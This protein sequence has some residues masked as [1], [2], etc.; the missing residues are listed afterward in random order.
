M[1]LPIQST[2]E[3]VRQCNPALVQGVGMLNSTLIY[4]PSQSSLRNASYQQQC[5]VCD[6]PGH[7]A[8]QYP[9][10]GNQEQQPQQYS[11]QSYSQQQYDT[12]YYPLVQ[13]H[14]PPASN[15]SRPVQEDR[16]MMA[17]TRVEE[18]EESCEKTQSRLLIVHK[19]DQGNEQL[20]R[21]P[22]I[23]TEVLTSSIPLL[24]QRPRVHFAKRAIP[25]AC[26]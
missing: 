24:R 22:P 4:G 9:W 10:K 7:Y 25:S 5:Y 21:P 8:Q 11:G 14:P 20:G 6:E 16:T 23:T 19:R 26:R 3:L 18:S 2:E 15:E 17:P 12:S 13:H 1:P